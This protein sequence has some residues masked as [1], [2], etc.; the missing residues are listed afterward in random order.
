MPRDLQSKN[1]PKAVGGLVSLKLTR[2]QWAVAAGGLVLMV[3]LGLVAADVMFAVASVGLRW[4]L[5]PAA[6]S[7]AGIAGY[8]CV[9]RPLTERRL[10]YRRQG[11]LDKDLVR[12]GGVPETEPPE[13]VVEEPALPAGEETDV[14]VGPRSG[15][16]RV[17]WLVALLGI[18][19]M[20]F[21]L[22]GLLSPRLGGVFEPASSGIHYIT[23]NIGVKVGDPVV[24]DA[25][26]DRAF[27]G[28][29]EL[30]RSRGDGGMVET[31]LPVEG[32]T[33]EG[34]HFRLHIPA[35]GSA[36][37]YHIRYSGSESG[38]YRV[39]VSGS[40]DE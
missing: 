14:E 28:G 10:H 20:A 8:W 5:V 32:S 30:W 37:D 19:A 31:M 9:Y 35:V 25:V 4:M 40:P 22:G 7:V 2:R 17:W 33:A 13:I 27:S 29:V 34:A 36:F 1:I 3:G 6:L 24:I 16:R 26:V 21:L 23:G 18:W 12:K 39:S 11:K 15:G 38:V